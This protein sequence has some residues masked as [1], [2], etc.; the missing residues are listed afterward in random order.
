MDV[1]KTMN[2][3]EAK[4]L[5]EAHGWLKTKGGKHNIKMEKSGCRPVTLPMH[6]RQNY[7]E[8][9][10]RRILKQAGII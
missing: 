7:S 1:P 2:Q 4:A 6:R 5:L 10:T 8:D 9:L 3:K